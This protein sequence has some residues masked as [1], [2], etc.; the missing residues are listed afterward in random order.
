MCDYTG[1]D[2]GAHYDDAACHNGYLWD[3]DG[4]GWPEGD[5]SRPCPKCNTA[6]FLNDAKDDAESTSHG[7]I[8]TSLYCGAMIIE[9]ALKKAKHENP[10]DAAK[11]CAKNPTITT[12]DWP[13]RKAVLERRA[14]LV[15]PVEVTIKLQ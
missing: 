13:N 3:L 8:M 12:W 14:A 7:T 4:D 11:W 5:Y 15:Y 2:F 9:G 1:K 6:E 10:A